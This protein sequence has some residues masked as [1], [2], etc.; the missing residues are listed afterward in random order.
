M[1]NIYLYTYVYVYIFFYYNSLQKT[2]RISVFLILYKLFHNNF[3]G[4]LTAN[5]KDTFSYACLLYIA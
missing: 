4:L 2:A 1:Y 5:N 3:F